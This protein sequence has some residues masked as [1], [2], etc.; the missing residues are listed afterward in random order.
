M[1]DKKGLMGHVKDYKCVIDTGNHPPIA[2]K[3]PNYGVHESE[4]MRKAIG[5]LLELKQVKQIHDGAWLSKA[6]LA[7]KPHQEH[8][9]HIKDF[10][11]RFCV[12]YVA[13]NTI[14]EL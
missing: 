12:N 1:F 5:K 7:P 13:L 4:I 11:W 10:V 3:N 6:L 8:I 9:T 2:C 14:T